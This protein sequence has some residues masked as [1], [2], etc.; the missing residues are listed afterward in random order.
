[1]GRREPDGDVIDD[2]TEGRA[3][4][5]RV[6][7]PR[8]PAGELEN[9]VLAVL[10]AADTA[11]VPA[12]VQD[13]LGPGLAYNTVQTILTRLHAKGAVERE[14]AGRAHAYRPVLDQ[15]GL[16]ARQMRGLLDRGSDR[17]AVLRRFVAELGGEDEAVLGE[18][19]RRTESTPRESGGS[20]QPSSVSH[21]PAPE[22]ARP[23]RRRSSSP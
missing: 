1:M 13:A 21:D 2:D 9:E 15:N 18:L 11:L 8:R 10:W 20:A 12:Q 5:A 22:T 4:S 7:G 16:T 14:R 3:R 19:L 23:R 6:A 17:T